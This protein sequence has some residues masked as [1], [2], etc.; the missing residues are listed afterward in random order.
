MDIRLLVLTRVGNR[1]TYASI[2]YEEIENEHDAPLCLRL[3]GKTWDML[4]RT[5]GSETLIPAFEEAWFA[6]RTSGL[7][8]G[9]MVLGLIDLTDVG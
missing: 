1:D 6:R 2:D 9:A 8:T 3:K 5:H 7:G 4:S